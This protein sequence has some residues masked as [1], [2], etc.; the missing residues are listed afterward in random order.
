MPRAD[1]ILIVDDDAELRRLLTGF[2]ERYGFRVSAVAD[3]DGMRDTVRTRQIDLIVLDLMLPGSDGVSLCRELR[4]GAHNANTPVIMLTARGDPVDRVVGLEVGADDYM[5]KP[6]DPRELMARIRSVLRRTRLPPIAQS[7]P[8]VRQLR[9]DG[10][11]LDVTAHTLTEPDGETRHALTDAEFRLL[12]LLVENAHRVLT[13]DD[14]MELTVGRQALPHDRRIDVQV[15]RLRNLLD[16]NGREPRLIRTV[17]NKGY[18]FC[19]DVE[20]R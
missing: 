4:S 19:A 14:I 16:D 6:F 18:Q 8:D 3:G 20:R 12:Q 1:H 13:R 11:T 17:R 15:C 5:P 9:F 10:W 7:G 2:L